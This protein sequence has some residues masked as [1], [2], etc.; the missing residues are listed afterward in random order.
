MSSFKVPC[1]S[2]EAQVLIKNP[3]LIGTKVECPKC[4]YRFKVEAPKEE[5]AAA[6]APAKVESA[7]DAGKKAKKKKML[8]GVGLGVLAVGLLGAGGYAIFGGDSKKPAG[9]T[10][11]PNPYVA[12]G[13]TIGGPDDPNKP[14]D[15]D[16]DKKPAKKLSLVPYS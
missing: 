6:E 4:K 13:G 11:N 10:G 3:N 15:E 9:Y 2:C 7:A 14:K 16:K 1:P 8:I 5:A 12:P